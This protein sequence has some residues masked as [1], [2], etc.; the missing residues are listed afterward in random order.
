ML[1]SSPSDRTWCRRGLVVLCK[2]RLGQE[3][4]GT[5]L[6][7]LVTLEEEELFDSSWGSKEGKRFEW[8]FPEAVPEHYYWR[9][10]VGEGGQ[11][12]G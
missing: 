11:A 9:G 1:A 4:I 8:A 12:T 3:G 5:L 7:R 10:G 2:A 6:H